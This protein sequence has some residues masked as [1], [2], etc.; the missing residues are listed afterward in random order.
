VGTHRVEDYIPG[1]FKE[2]TLLI[3]ENC[4]V[5]SLKYMAG[6]LVLPVELLGIDTIEL[7]R[8]NVV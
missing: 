2:V 4:L 3:D 5:A 8:R 6:G 1:E 7:S